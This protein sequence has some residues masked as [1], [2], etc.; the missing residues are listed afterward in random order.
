M[1]ILIILFPILY[2]SVF[3]P[4]TV[5]I[6]ERIEAEESLRSSEEKFRAVAQS[7]NDAIV[8]V[9]SKGKITGWNRGAEKMFGYKES[10]MMELHISAPW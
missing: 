6:K 8:T 2:F 5:S 10:E 3:R 9:D 7:A 1:L 4:Q